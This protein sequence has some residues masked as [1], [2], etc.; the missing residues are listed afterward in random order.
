MKE[1]ITEEDSRKGAK[2]TETIIA[3]TTEDA[4]LKAQNS[5]YVAAINN[6]RSVGSVAST[7]SRSI[8]P[9][10]VKVLPKNHTTKVLFAQKEEA[11]QFQAADKKHKAEAKRRVQQADERRELAT[12]AARQKQ[13][14]KEE[15]ETNLQLQQLLAASAKKPKGYKEVVDREITSVLLESNLDPERSEGGKAAGS[16]ITQFLRPFKT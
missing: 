2:F 11:K 14:A 7:S 9:K 8:E 4:I 6:E 12:V 5:G 10:R 3:M 13:Q 16:R 15:R 1:V